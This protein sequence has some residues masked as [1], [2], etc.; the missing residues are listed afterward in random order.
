[1]SDSMMDVKQIIAKHASEF[2]KTFISP[3]EFIMA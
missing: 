2:Y 1:M 3:Y